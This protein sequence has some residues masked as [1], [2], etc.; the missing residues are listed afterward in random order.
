MHRSACQPPCNPRRGLRAPHLWPHVA[1]GAAGEGCPEGR[2]Q[3]GAAGED[4]ARPH[5]PGQGGYRQCGERGEGPRGWQGPP[6][7]WLAQTGQP[8]WC[9]LCDPAGWAGICHDFIHKIKSGCLNTCLNEPFSRASA[10]LLQL[11]LSG[12]CCVL[13]QPWPEWRTGTPRFAARHRPSPGRRITARF[14]A[15]LAYCGGGNWTCGISEACLCSFS[16][17]SNASL[18]VKGEEWKQTEPRSPGFKSWFHRLLPP[19]W[20]TGDHK[21]RAH[22]CDTTESRQSPW[23]CQRGSSGPPRAAPRVVRRITTLSQG[24]FVGGHSVTAAVARLRLLQTLV[25][26]QSEVWGSP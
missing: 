4:R 1:A 8:L 13:G 10:L 19:N 3:T 14:I 6:G 17:Q 22:R 24:S 15:R 2:A 21:G 5:G 25:G 12:L 26:G 7:C 16:L 11:G 18:C 9:S 23:G 20:Q